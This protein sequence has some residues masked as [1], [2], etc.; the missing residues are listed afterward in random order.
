MKPI[1]K[2]MPPMISWFPSTRADENLHI[3]DSSG[4]KTG[5]SVDA[6]KKM[7][8]GSTPKEKLELIER[9]AKKAESE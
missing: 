7:V 5:V 4:P 1:G 9:E 3:I 2:E 6:D 8:G